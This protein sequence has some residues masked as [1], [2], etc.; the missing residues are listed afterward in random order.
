MTALLEVDCLTKR[1]GGVEALHQVSVSIGEAS[2]VGII[3]PN[4]AGKT[5]LFNVVSG[6]LK[7]D[8]GDVRFRG[9]SISRLRPF[10]I[11]RQGLV[12]TF[13]GV[14]P[15][16]ELSVLENVMVGAQRVSERGVLGSLVALRRRARSEREIE[17]RARQV[18]AEF[19]LEDKSSMPIRQMSSFG[20][21]RLIELARALAAEPDLLMLDEPAAGLDPR[22][23]ERFGEI[24][25]RLRTR[26]LS[27][28]L[29][30][31]DVE[32]VFRLCTTVTVLDY[33]RVIAQGDPAAVSQDPAVL[34]AYLGTK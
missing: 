31:H 24:L 2:I 32:L 17:Q 18:L 33:G 4:G 27:A 23:V 28:V 25:S 10:A 13:Q 12:R 11:A 5:T 16:A 7:S 30:E 14:K 1:F 19:G 15:L 9:A 21:L 29:I 3:G 20:D 8:G 34:S 26:G 6:F 22:E